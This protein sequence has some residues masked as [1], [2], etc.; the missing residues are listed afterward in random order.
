MARPKLQSEPTSE[1]STRSPSR[2]HPALRLLTFRLFCEFQGG[3]SRVPFVQSIVSDLVPTLEFTLDSSAGVAM[4]AC[5]L[6]EKRRQANTAMLQEALAKA[7]AQLGTKEAGDGASPASDAGAADATEA[8]DSPAG[9]DEAEAGSQPAAG[10]DATEAAT[11]ATEAAAGAGAGAGAGADATA[12][13][14]EASFA[15]EELKL[16]FVVGEFVSDAPASCG[17]LSEEDL[18]AI[19][20]VEDVILAAENDKRAL[21]EARNALESYVLQMQSLV[22][23]SPL[24]DDE[25]CSPILLEAEDF[26]YGEGRTAQDFTERLNEVRDKIHELCPAYFEEEQRKRLQV[27]KE[28]EVQA[29]IEAEIRAKEQEDGTAADHDFRKMKKEDRMRLMQKNKEEG[30]ELFT[31]GNYK[32]AAIRYVKA[33]NHGNKLKDIVGNG[34]DEVNKLFVSCYLNLSQCYLKLEKYTKAYASAKDAHDLEPENIKALYRM[35]LASW[36]QKDVDDTEAKIKL[37]LAVDPASKP[38]LKLQQKVKRARAQEKA[39]RKKMAK[40]M[41]S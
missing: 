22:Y 21:D 37:A 32:S 14:T 30:N 38:V 39:R 26:L 7:A 24:L 41:F 15:D 36:N 29:K 25:K 10:T 1:T 11:D 2:T 16:K 28:L 23:E 17:K 12:A 9:D 5:L 18:A 27:E 19:A 8:A 34:N 35:A 40:A 6:Q 13:A 33:V 3:G 4:G 31:D 20:K